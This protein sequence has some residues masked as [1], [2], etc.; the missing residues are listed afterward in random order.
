MGNTSLQSIFGEMG[1]ISSSGYKGLISSLSKKYTLLGF[2]CP[3]VPEEMIHAA[4]A[5]PLRIMGIPIKMPHV[6]AY[7]PLN[8]CHF[9]KSSLENLLQGEFDLLRGIVFSHSC[10]TMQGLSD[11][12]SLQRRIPL[13]F[14][15][16]TPSNLD[17]EFS[18]EYLKA[19]IE[20]FKDFLE[21]HVGKITS[22]SLQASIH[23]FNQIREKTQSLYTLRVK[24]PKGIPGKDFAR[25]VRA[26][27]LMDRQRYLD[28]LN[29]LLEALSEKAEETEPLIPVFLAGNMV[30]SDSYFSLIEEAGALIVQ[31][32][33]C[34]GS[35]FFRLKVQE[36]L[37]P[38]EALTRRYLQT[39]T[40]PTKFKGAYAH[41]ETLLN[42]VQKSRAKG[43]IFLLYKYCE[44]HF[45]DYPDLKQALELKGIPTLLLEVDDPLTSQGQLKIRIQAFVEMLS[46]I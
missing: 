40:C 37:D 3:Y 22:S 16:M 26:G 28:L 6:H 15:L 7:L 13:Q 10:D 42:E 36:D 25:M 18:Y 1:A 19:E 23:L 12:W 32:D 21:T 14:N 31:D 9:V 45:F 27:Y 2:F 5:F 17:S 29:E 8:C 11:I 41:I 34:S 43:V 38:L 20:R 44:N 4:G 39:F 35:R 46:S 30:H 33:L 24:Y